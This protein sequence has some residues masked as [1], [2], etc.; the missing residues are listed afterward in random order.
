MLN[1]VSASL[2]VDTY[3]IIMEQEAYMGFIIPMGLVKLPS[4]YDYWRK[5]E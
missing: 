4:I 3:D 5:D 1:N 2:T